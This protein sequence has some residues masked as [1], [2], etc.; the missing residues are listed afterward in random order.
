MLQ[1]LEFEEKKEVP[2]SA[3]ATYAQNETCDFFWCF[4]LNGRSPLVWGN[5]HVLLCYILISKQFE[6]ISVCKSISAK[7]HTIWIHFITEE[8][9]DPRNLKVEWE[10]HSLKLPRRNK[11]LRAGLIK[12][13]NG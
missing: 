2:K 8:K 3:C 5:N 9:D 10:L 7:N 1:I 12:G 6:H 13:T 11:G 4:L